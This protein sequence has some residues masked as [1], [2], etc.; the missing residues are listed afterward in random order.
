MAEEKELDLKVVARKIAQASQDGY[1]DWE[2][3]Q[4]LYTSYPQLLSKDAYD[5]G[6][7]EYIDG[8]AY[9]EFIMVMAQEKAPRSELKYF[10]NL[11]HNFLD[12]ATFGL[13]KKV[14]AVEVVVVCC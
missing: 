2:I 7:G 10:A 11:A 8:S 12:T 5:G 13:G 1:T 4:A 9:R 6:T 14:A 3:D